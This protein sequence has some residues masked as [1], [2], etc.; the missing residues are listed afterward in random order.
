MK[1][2]E[3]LDELSVTG[4]T[5]AKIAQD[6]VGI[7]EKRLKNALHNAGYE[8]RNKNPKGWFYAKEGKEPLYQSVFEFIESKNS[9][10]NV[11]QSSP[12]LNITLPRSSQPITLDVKSVINEGEKYIHT[13]FTPEEVTIL[14]ELIKAYVLDDQQDSQR[15]DLYQRVVT[16]E[17]G[18]KVRKTIVINEEVGTLLDRFADQQ[19]FNKSDIIEL[20]ILDLINKYK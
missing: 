20:A 12:D 10:P 5:I 6:K 13:V 3:L 7:G 4:N 2:K 15:D 9:L 18:N 17:K 11:K 8:Y 19:K 16:L 14:K 1:I